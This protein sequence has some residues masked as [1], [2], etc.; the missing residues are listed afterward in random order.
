MLT[1][2]DIAATCERLGKKCTCGNCG[3][4]DRLKEHVLNGERDA[5]RRELQG[6]I[7]ALKGGDVPYD[8]IDELSKAQQGLLK[9][10]IYIKGLLAHA[11]DSPAK[12]ALVEELSE[13]SRLA[14]VTPALA[15]FCAWFRKPR[16][17]RL[18]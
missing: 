2:K 18:P 12:Q 5:A 3:V 8:H 10:I 17:S 4:T 15:Y 1:A 13:A 11:P 6:E 7:V 16:R 9:R 14:A